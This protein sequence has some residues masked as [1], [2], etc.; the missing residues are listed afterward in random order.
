MQHS[1][2]MKML[3]M[4][5]WAITALVSINMLTSM[6]NYDFF[7]YVIGM[8]PGMMVPVVWIVGF[9][10][11]VS[12]AMLVKATFMCCPGCGACPCSCNK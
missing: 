1:Q 11:F 10:G 5:T 7:S 12:L 6:Y 3:G 8:M 2:M 4:V 9:S